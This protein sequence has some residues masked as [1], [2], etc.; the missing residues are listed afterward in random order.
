MKVIRPIKIAPEMIVQSTVPEN[1][2]E[3]W[4]IGDS[5]GAGTRVI[6][7]DIQHGPSVFQSVKD[8]NKGHRPDLNPDE[9]IRV[10]PTNL[11]A[12][13][14]GSASILSESPAGFS[15]SFRPGKAFDSLAFFKVAGA[16]IRV[17]IVLDS[18]GTVVFER[19][20]DLLNDALIVDG[21]AYCFVEADGWNQ[22]EL[23]VTVHI[24]IFGSGITGL[25]EVVVGTLTELDC[26][27]IEVRQSIRDYS[28]SKQ[29]DFNSAILKKDAYA[30]RESWSMMVD[31]SQ[32]FY[33][34]NILSELRGALTVFIAPEGTG[35]ELLTTFGF[36]KNW[37]IVILYPKEI[38]FD[39]DI[40]RLK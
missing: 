7:H 40:Q 3:I 31:K 36:L 23:G 12:M 28:R 19:S 5:Y 21:Y 9:W 18:E 30:K 15:C 13:F 33:V 24:D 2:E 20:L 26:I 25:G 10:G 14:D 37:A 6:H 27:E 35:C 22:S 16:S 1:T 4:T 38:L 29:G 34:S 39:V 11:W 32:R 17:R 8:A